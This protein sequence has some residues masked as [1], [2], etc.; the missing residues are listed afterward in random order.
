MH[1]LATTKSGHGYNIPHQHPINPPPNPPTIALNESSLCPPAIVPIELIEIV[2][3]ATLSKKASSVK[4]CLF[5]KNARYNRI[6]QLNRD[7]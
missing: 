3:K 4:N 2:E 1:I 7:I 6:K 5:G